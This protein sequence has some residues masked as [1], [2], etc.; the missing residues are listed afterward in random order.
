MSWMKDGWSM[1]Q[2]VLMQ[3]HR[4][5]VRSQRLMHA[6]QYWLTVKVSIC[7]CHNFT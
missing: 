1:E 7:K 5:R 6:L 2:A 4:H 3:L